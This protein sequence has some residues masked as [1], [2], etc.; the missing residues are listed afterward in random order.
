MRCWAPSS[1]PRRT[2]LER[3]HRAIDRLA[4]GDT[5]GYLHDVLLNGV[6]RRAAQTVL[7]A[8]EVRNDAPRREERLGERLHRGDGS[9]PVRGRARL[10]LAEPVEDTLGEGTDARF[11]MGDGEGPEGRQPIVRALGEKGVLGFL[12]ILAHDPSLARSP[13]QA[14]SFFRAVKRRGPSFCGRARALEGAPRR[15]H[16]RAVDQRC[17]QLSTMEAIRRPSLTAAS[18]CPIVTKESASWRTLG[19]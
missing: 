12:R 13:S 14:T 7:H 18:S 10:D 8:H 9:F 4:L 5:H 11:D 16:E 17:R 3:V 6:V 19:F 15:G 1:R 2:R